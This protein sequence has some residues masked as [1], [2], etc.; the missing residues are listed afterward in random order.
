MGG[1]RKLIA[2]LL[3][4]LAFGV[5]VAV[6][7]GQDT[8]VRDAL[9]NT[10]A[11]WVVVP[12]LAGTRYTNVWRAALVGLATTLAAF[13]GFYLAEAAILDLGEHPWYTDLQL[14]LGSGQVYE[15]WGLLSGSVYGALGGLWATRWRLA[16]V[17]A[18]ALAFVCEPLIVLFLWKA[19]IWGDGGLLLHY[20]WMWI[21]EIL[22]GFAAVAFFVTRRSARLAYT[23]QV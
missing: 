2:L 15:K 21:G 1:G 11:P 4:G 9:G 14:T 23:P 20:R 12:F 19:R 17:V 3:A 7:K 22:I 13:L 5:L 16:G 8:G 18:V 10:S 6:V